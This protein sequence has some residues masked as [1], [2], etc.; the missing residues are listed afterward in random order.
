MAEESVQR[1]IIHI[2]MDCFY[3]AV[4]VRDNPTYRGQPI[5][6]GGRSDR[7]GVIATCSYEA[8]EYGVRSA[9]PSAHARKL[10]PELVILPPN[11]KKYKA[12][13]EKIRQIMARYTDKIEPLSL[14]EAYLDTSHSEA[15]RGSATLIA[16]AIRDDIYRVTKLTAS[17]GVAPSKFLAKIASDWNKPNGIKVITPDDVDDFVFHLPVA[18]IHGVGK[19]TAQK[20]RNLGINTCGELRELSQAELIKK[21]GRFGDTLY[22]FARGIDNREVKARSER[23]SVSVERTY[24]EDMSTLQECQQELPHLTSRLSVRLGGGDN[25]HR[26]QKLFV[27]LKFSDFTITTIETSARRLDVNVFYELLEQ[28][29]ERKQLAVRLMGI[30]VRLREAPTQF[31][32]LDIPFP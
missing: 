32:Q 6:V 29:F 22:R 1:K 14:D 24:S 8:R 26:I 7:R 21:F 11:M 13:S 19:V 30:G 28:A 10:C 3:A 9:M 15:F 4:E 12:E 20:I 16:N 23:K 2:D 25:I 17:A 5:A 18:K 31:E 27:K